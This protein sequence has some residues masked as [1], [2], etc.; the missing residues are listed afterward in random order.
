LFIN[1]QHGICDSSII[2]FY[3]CYWDI[4]FLVVV[5]VVVVAAAAAAAVVQ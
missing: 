3:Y 4:N 5:V 2:N 1:L